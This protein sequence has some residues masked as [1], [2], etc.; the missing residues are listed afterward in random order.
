MNYE[1]RKGNPVAPSMQA[2]KEEWEERN[3]EDKIEAILSIRQ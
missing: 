3:V 1:I 2:M